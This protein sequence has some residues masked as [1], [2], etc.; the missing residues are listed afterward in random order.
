MTRE[1]YLNKLIWDYNK[2]KSEQTA[3]ST[4]YPQGN[5]KKKNVNV[6]RKNFLLK[7]L[8]NFTVLTSVRHMGLL[9]HIT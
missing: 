5:F 7:H 6:V 2:H 4:K 8:L 9:K 1:E 3:N